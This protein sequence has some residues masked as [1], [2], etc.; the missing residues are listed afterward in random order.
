[1]EILAQLGNGF[2]VALTV[3]MVFDAVAIRL[4]SEDVAGQHV[5]TNWTFTDLQGDDRQWML[6]LQNQSLHYVRGRHDEAAAVTIELTKALLADIMVGATTFV[7]A[8]Q[9]GDITID[10][11]AGAL[12]AIFGNLDVFETSFAIIEP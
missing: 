12:L 5:V 4:R 2:A 9:A 10:G 1:M 3:D 11:D 6:A 8:T 7:D